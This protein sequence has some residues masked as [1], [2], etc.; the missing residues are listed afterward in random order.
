MV[1]FRPGDHRPADAA[2]SGLEPA[3]PGDRQFLGGR[4]ARENA[5]RLPV[6]DGRLPMRQGLLEMARVEANISHP[7]ASD[8]LLPRGRIA[9]FGFS[10]LPCPA[11]E[12]LPLHL[13]RSE[14]PT[15]RKCWSL[16]EQEKME[17][18][19]WFEVPLHPADTRMEDRLSAGHGAT[20]RQAS[21]GEVNLPTHLKV[22]D[23]ISPTDL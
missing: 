6:N 16:A 17:I 22:D 15:R 12:A 4:V 9:A 11:P 14:W 10:R 1:F 21:R 3:G 2:L 5:P 19:S 20:R 7:Q 8:G 13:Y 18:G 23:F